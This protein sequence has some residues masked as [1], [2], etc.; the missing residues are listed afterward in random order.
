MYQQKLSMKNLRYMKPQTFYKKIISLFA[1]ACVACTGSILAQ[2]DKRITQA[3]QYFAKG[4]YYTAAK[5]YEQYL[6][7]SSKQIVQANFPLNS[8]KRCYKE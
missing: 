7:P 3:E 8:M 1:F 5:L 4:D 6:V 2:T